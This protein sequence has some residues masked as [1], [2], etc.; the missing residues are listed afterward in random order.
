MD[1]C[2]IGESGLEML[3]KMSE[4]DKYIINKINMLFDKI[5]LIVDKINYMNDKINFMIAKLN[6]S[7]TE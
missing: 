7:Y 4:N 1:I 3:N 5:D 2:I 6:K